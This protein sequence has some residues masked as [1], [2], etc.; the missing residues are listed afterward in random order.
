MRFIFCTYLAPI[1][2]NP[3]PLP[4]MVS[5]RSMGPTNF[6]HIP[7]H[8]TRPFLKWRS[9][10][11]FA[12]CPSPLATIIINNPFLCSYDHEFICIPANKLVLDVFNISSTPKETPNS[13]DRSMLLFVWL[14]LV[15]KHLS[16]K[17]EVSKARINWWDWF[18]IWHL[19]TKRPF[20][21]SQTK[22][23]VAHPRSMQSVCR[24]KFSGLID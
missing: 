3:P 23:I 2:I 8:L 5:T 10:C 22:S 24:W 14:N 11:I 12:S 18:F 9:L 1:K 4:F 17:R 15:D 20:Y 7:Q 19:S 6:S 21:P 16:H 13:I